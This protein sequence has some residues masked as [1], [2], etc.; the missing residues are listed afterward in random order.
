MTTESKRCLPELGRRGE[1]WVAV[2]GVLLAAIALSALV[3]R[4]WPEEL[5]VAAWGVG[6]VLLG[7][8]ALLLA[9]GG[10]RL[11]PAL[12]PL[13]AP[14]AGQ[15]LRTTGI[16]GRARHPI[17]GGVILL[18]L[19]WSTVFASVVGL[20]LTALLVL[21]LE[22]KSRREEQWLDERHHPAYEEYRRRTPRRFIPYVY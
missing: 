2:Q 3:G 12:T 16:Y 8:G 21:L 10:L 15:Q 14:R 22:L 6:G 7:L 17:Y 19:G 13:P 20:A 4:G 11:G 18:A 9:I 1:G 5:E